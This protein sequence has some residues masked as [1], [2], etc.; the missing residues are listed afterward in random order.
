MEKLLASELG[1]LADGLNSEHSPKVLQIA[2]L[3]VLVCD[4]LNDLRGRT[5]MNT[6]PIIDIP[7]SMMQTWQDTAGLF[8]EDLWRKPTT[9]SV[10][11]V[12]RPG[13]SLPHPSRS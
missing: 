2:C 6:Q 11:P 10:G 4:H 12:R 7:K 1:Q 13:C 5:G 8:S 3:R 9:P